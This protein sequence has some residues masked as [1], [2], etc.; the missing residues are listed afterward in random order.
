MAH[1]KM[2]W[3]VRSVVPHFLVIVSVSVK[4]GEH[5]QQPG[6]NGEQGRKRQLFLMPALPG[7]HVMGTRTAAAR[8]LQSLE[9]L[10]THGRHPLGMASFALVAGLVGWPLYCCL[11]ELAAAP[12]CDCLPMV[13]L[14]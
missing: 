5:L 4:P 10:C 2:R 7:S 3:K 1:G 11:N 12:R 8:Q 9:P 6:N 13:A 14:S